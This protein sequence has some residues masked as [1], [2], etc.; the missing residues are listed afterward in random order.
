VLEAIYAVRLGHV[1]GIYTWKEAK[2]QTVGTY[3]DF[4]YFLSRKN[5]YERMT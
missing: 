5:A 2:P 4:Q 1:P 3:T